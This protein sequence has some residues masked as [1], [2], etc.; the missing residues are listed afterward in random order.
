MF[1]ASL[2]AFMMIVALFCLIIFTANSVNSQEEKS[3]TTPSAAGNV[4]S[5]IVVEEIGE[6]PLLKEKPVGTPNVA[7]VDG[8]STD[9]PVLGEDED[10]DF[11]DYDPDDFAVLGNEWLLK[12]IKEIEEQIQTVSSDDEDVGDVTA[13]SPEANATQSI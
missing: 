12:E 10:D 2:L 3:S 8:K 11:E 13:K 5:G 4:K 6:S 1:K 7:S 9:I